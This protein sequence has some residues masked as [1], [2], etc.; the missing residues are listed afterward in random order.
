MNNKSHS[1]TQIKADVL[2]LLQSMSEEELYE[3]NKKLKSGDGNKSSKNKGNNVQRLLEYFLKFKPDFEGARMTF[4]AAY[5]AVFGEF[6]EKPN[7]AIN[8]YCNKLKNKVLAFIKEKQLE[9]NEGIQNFLLAQYFAEKGLDRE[10]NKIK[11]PEK[12]DEDYFLFSYLLAKETFILQTSSPPRKYTSEDI[13]KQRMDTVNNLHK[14]YLLT[15][16]AYWVNDTNFAIS[17]S[18]K[19]TLV[20]PDEK[21]VE[22]VKSICTKEE[23]Q[24][25]ELWIESREFILGHSKREEFETKVKKLQHLLPS[26]DLANLIYLLLNDF[27]RKEKNYFKR[28]VLT[29]E[30]FLLLQE[31]GI[32]SSV[33]LTPALWLRV[34][35]VSLELNRFDWINQETL[36]YAEKNGDGS[37][38]LFMMAKTLQGTANL[39][40]AKRF[41]KIVKKKRG[42]SKVLVE[43]ILKSMTH[44]LELA[45]NCF[46]E[47]SIFVNSR[48]NFERHLDRLGDENSGLTK[49]YRL[50]LKLTN[51]LHTLDGTSNAYFE[52]DEEAENFFGV[53]EIVYGEYWLQTQ[54][55]PFIKSAFRLKEEREQLKVQRNHP[56]HSVINRDRFRHKIKQVEKGFDELYATANQHFLAF[57]EDIIS[58]DEA[59]DNAEALEHRI[60]I[61]QSL[62]DRLWLLNEVFELK[63][64]QI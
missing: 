36:D 34:I 41:L 11:S 48:V 61:E 39:N 21:L 44:R 59:K 60:C 13:A 63:K 4:R 23:K 6:T 10:L 15:Y 62:V 25:I 24:V 1:N 46:E 57:Y 50:F 18:Q 51:V 7:R 8:D 20:E 43:Q 30:Y 64:A 17:R 29:F 2:R 49:P 3:L 38:E 42:N 12:I 5:R 9:R 54:F 35:S 45:L 27:S 55:E 58:F 47:T 52:A 31:K 32:L 14:Y 16:I 26:F 22:N 56:K 19:E 53:E 40:E 37:Y 33:S 28:S